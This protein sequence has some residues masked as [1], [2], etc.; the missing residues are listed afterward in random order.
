[1][2]HR[3][4]GH[5]A[6]RMEE[7]YNERLREGA[8]TDAAQFLKRNVVHLDLVP[9]GMSATHR[10]TLHP[11]G[12]DEM[13][14][15]ENGFYH[16]NFERGVVSAIDRSDWEETYDR[17]CDEADEAHGGAENWRWHAKVVFLSSA[18]SGLKIKPRT[19]PS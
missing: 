7:D 10:L 16:R 6:L 4:I 5:V 19:S 12:N 15:V 8:I 17:I 11:V 14:P 1:M 3:D 18:P 9:N 2:F 13:I